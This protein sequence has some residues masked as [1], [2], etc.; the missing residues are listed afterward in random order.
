MSTASHLNEILDTLGTTEIEVSKSVEELLADG[1][2][3]EEKDVYAA[4]L[5]L[6]AIER[7][8]NEMQTV[9]QLAELVIRIGE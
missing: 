5:T 2:T 9:K 1:I 8:N 7:I 4:Q 3:L 6:D